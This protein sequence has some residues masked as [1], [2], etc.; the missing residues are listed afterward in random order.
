MYE[1]RLAVISI[2]VEDRERSAEINALLSTYGG[3][4]IGRMGIP[5]KEKGVSVI[6]VII[7][8]P[9]EAINTLTGKI[10]M[11]SGVTAKTL[12]SKV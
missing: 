10:G 12:T 8:A 9:Q 6:C 11:L 5:Y 3:Y 2:I 4:I 1:N 7:D